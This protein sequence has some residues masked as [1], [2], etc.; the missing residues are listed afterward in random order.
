MVGVVFRRGVFLRGREVNSPQRP[1]YAATPFDPTQPRSFGI[2]EALKLGLQGTL[3]PTC[4]NN[5]DYTQ[6]DINEMIDRGWVTRFRQRP[7]DKAWT[8]A[9]TKQG[10]RVAQE[11]V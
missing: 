1:N 10:G 4:D 3:G 9:L 7:F 2:V 11:M 5:T 8:Y 6:R